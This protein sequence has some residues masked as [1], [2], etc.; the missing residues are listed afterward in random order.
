MP[1]QLISNQSSGMVYYPE[2]PVAMAEDDT[3]SSSQK[4]STKSSSDF[5]KNG[6]AK[7]SASKT[8]EAAIVDLS[9][10]QILPYIPPKGILPFNHSMITPEFKKYAAEKLN[11]TDE[12]RGK[13]IEE[14]RQLVIND[15]DLEVTDEDDLIL[16]FLRSRKFDVKRAFDFMKLGLSYVES[17]RYILEREDP[18]IVRRVIKTNMIGFLPYRDTEGRAII[19]SRADCWNPDE[20]PAADCIFTGVMAVQSAGHN[21]VNQI[22]GFIVILDL[23][24]LKVHQVLAMSRWMIFGAITLQRACP[25]FMKAFHVINTPPFYKIGW[26]L[27]KPLLSEK[28]RKRF[29]FHKSSDLSTL[30]EFVPKEI[31]PKELGGPISFSNDH[32][33]KDID[34]I[35]KEY[36]YYLNHNCLRS[37]KK[38]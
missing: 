16:L 6:K 18:A 13:A 2:A 5:K 17:Y 20:I 28:I 19:Y 7:K 10:E 33:A 29:I 23:K 36:Y 25:C 32:W 3:K 35:E 21:P 1:F 14:F 26:K 8:L 22:A 15:P 31:L 30:Y 24:D 38:K 11:E 9:I 34:R 12:V 27:V 37:K 4:S